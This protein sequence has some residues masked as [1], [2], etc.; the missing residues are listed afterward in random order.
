MANILVRNV[1]TAILN[2]LKQ[3]AKVSRRSLQQEI[4]SVLEESAIMD[5]EQA[6]EVAGRIRKQLQASGKTFSDS[7]E[8]VREDRGW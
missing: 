4:I 5:V 7:T 1:P 2:V 3:K 8:L 6:D